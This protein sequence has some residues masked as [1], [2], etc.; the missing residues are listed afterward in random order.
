MNEKYLQQFVDNQKKA[1]AENL[2]TD[3]MKYVDSS[4]VAKT[5]NV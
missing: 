1:G 4:L 3:A 5:L 2:P